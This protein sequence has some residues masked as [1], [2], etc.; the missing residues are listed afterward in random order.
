MI[1]WTVSL[2]GRVKRRCSAGNLI[3]GSELRRTRSGLKVVSWY[4]KHIIR[5]LGNFPWARSL[6]QGRLAPWPSSHPDRM[7]LHVLRPGLLSLRQLVGLMTQKAAVA[8]LLSA[9]PV[10]R[11]SDWDLPTPPTSVQEVLLIAL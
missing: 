11:A 7:L 6:S 1:P 9:Y 4:Q 3:I 5:K 10:L 8:P 2:S